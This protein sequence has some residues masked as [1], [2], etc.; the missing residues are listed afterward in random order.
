MLDQT[1]V[2]GRILLDQTAV[3]GRIL[4]DQTAH[5]SGVTR[6]FVRGGGLNKFS[7]RQRTERTGM[8]GAVAPYSGV[9]EAAV[10]WYKKFISYS[11]IFLIFG[12]LRLFRLGFV[13]TSEFR[14]GGGGGVK[15]PKP[16]P[17]YATGS[18]SHSC[19]HSVLCCS[20]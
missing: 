8:W 16:L 11:N 17:R 6:N 14:G 12:T 3:G 20:C 10:I 2:G 19:A 15:H 7:W 13:T 4:L 5:I 18:Y 1:A 9:L